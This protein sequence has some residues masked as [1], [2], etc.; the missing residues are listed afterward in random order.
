MSIS[1]IVIIVLT[2]I[3]VVALVILSRTRKRLKEIDGFKS[4]KEPGKEDDEGVI[5]SFGE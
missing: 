5:G 3:I 4:I 1:S 2:V